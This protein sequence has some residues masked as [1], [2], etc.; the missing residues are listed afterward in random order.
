[1]STVTSADGTAIAH[2]QTGEGPVVVIVGGALSTAADA[3][4]MAEALAA[5]GFRAVT[6]DRRGRGASGDTRGS[7]PRR[8]VED[9][10]AVIEATA[11][12]G[13]ASVLGHSSGAVL[14]LYAASLGVPIRAL[15]L[16]EPP[17]RF[18]VD[19]PAD[20][21]ADRLQTL[22]DEGRGED[23]VAT[24]QVEGV[25]L[26][27]E[28]VE[29]LRGSGQLAALAPLGQSAV[30]DVL[31]TREVSTPTDEMLSVGVPV[32]ILRG[33]QTFPVLITAADRLAEQMDAAELV[34]VPASVMHRP[35]PE[36]TAQVVQERLAH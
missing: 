5:A 33:E 27:L 32:T 17:F 26:P 9:L 19:E 4:P 24:F 10:S 11:A 7:T 25:G 13:E 34:V 30:Y 14:A 15:F 36:A 18:G 8:E 28:M 29:G 20:D 2:E 6:Y 1:M 16:S 23:A 31:L 22:V 12:A 3:A 21:L 35:D